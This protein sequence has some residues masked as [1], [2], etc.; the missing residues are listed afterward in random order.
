MNG[1][2]AMKNCRRGKVEASNAQESDREAVCAAGHEKE[3]LYWPLLCAFCGGKEK[4][5]EEAGGRPGGG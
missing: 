2:G 4:G 5:R 3:C 1:L